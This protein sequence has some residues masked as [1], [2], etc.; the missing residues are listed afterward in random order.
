[1][2]SPYASNYD[3]AIKYSD[4]LGNEGEECC[5]EVWD[6]ITGVITNVTTTIMVMP[7]ATKAKV[8]EKVQNAKDNIAIDNAKTGTTFG[9]RVLSSINENL[10]ASVSPAPEFTETKVITEVIESKTVPKIVESTTIEKPVIHG[11]SKNSPKPTV[12][13]K[14]EHNDGTY[15][16]TGIT[17][18]KNPE[19]RYSK[20]FMKDKK[21]I[22]LDRGSRA[23]MLNKERQI[24]KKNPGPFNRERWAGSEK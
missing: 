19:A 23:D 4:P 3:N 22:I 7:A 1:M 16:K 5:K 24:V 17:S 11:N 14:L 2:W 8:E 6:R 9:Q 15:L 12:L 13:Y 18:N 20:S 10:L 21:M